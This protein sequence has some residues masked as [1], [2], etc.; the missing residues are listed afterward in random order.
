MRDITKSALFLLCLNILKLICSQEVEG[1]PDSATPYAEF[2][3]FCGTF[4]PVHGNHKIIHTVIQWGKW[5]KGPDDMTEIG[6]P[7]NETINDGEEF[8]FCTAGRSFEPGGTNGDVIIVET[9]PNV[10]LP[11]QNTSIRWNVPFTSS[12]SQKITYSIE[13]YNITTY[14]MPIKNCQYNYVYELRRWR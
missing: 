8:R 13:F 12:F 5:V 11:V 6:S 2:L 10:N 1:I 3:R 7:V 14:H 4:K 9:T